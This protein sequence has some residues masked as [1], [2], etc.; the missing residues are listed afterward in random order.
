MLG[1]YSSN[2][3]VSPKSLTLH[4]QAQYLIANHLY[5]SGQRQ[6]AADAYGRLL[7][8]Y[9]VDSERNLITILL[10]R[11]RAHDLGDTIGAIELLEELSS[12]IHDDETKAMIDAD[13]EAIRSI[14][15]ADDA[16]G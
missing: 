16:Q 12:K 6:E 9:P 8:A 15:S 11:I 1:D 7:E 14:Q 5:Q 10:A 4:R 13:L 3:K 2:P